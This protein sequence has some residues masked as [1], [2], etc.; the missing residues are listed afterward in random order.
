MKRLS[1]D[2]FLTN[3]Q[4]NCVPEICLSCFKNKPIYYPSRKHKILICSFCNNEGREWKRGGFPC[5][6]LKTEKSA[7]ISKKKGSNCINLCVKFSTE[8]V[9]LRVSNRKKSKIFS[10]RAFFSYVF[11][12]ILIE[13]PKFYE[14]F[15]ALKN[16]WLHACYSF[17]FILQKNS[18]Q[19][20][21]V[22]LKGW[23]NI[24]LKT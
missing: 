23:Y 3:H 19:N 8:K 22:K 21:Y 1:C 20:G 9:V 11:D 17:I 16:V 7:L 14:T 6:F 24:A 15:L 5:S 10:C 13:V 12:K 4:P 18:A 2:T